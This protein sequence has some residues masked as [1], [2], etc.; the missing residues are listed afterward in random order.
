VVN[1]VDAEL[2]LYK[3]EQHLP[4]KKDDESFNNPLDWWRLKEQQYPLLAA[5]AR[6]VIAIPAT[7]APSE[8]VFSV[9][10]ITI[11]KERSKLG[12]MKRV[13]SLGF[14]HGCQSLCKAVTTTF[15]L[16]FFFTYKLK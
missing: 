6:K 12:G 1:R 11:A 2:L 3:W 15:P 9:A 8:R 14:F 5:M 16:F 7:S 4:L 13:C 10:G